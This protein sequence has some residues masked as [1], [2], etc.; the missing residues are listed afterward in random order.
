MYNDELYYTQQNCSSF[1]CVAVYP[2]II[3]G[4]EHKQK[5]PE[6]SFPQQ[7]IGVFFL[8]KRSFFFVVFRYVF[9]ISLTLTYDS[10]RYPGPL[11][12]PCFSLALLLPFTSQTTRLSVTSGKQGV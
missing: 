8:V 9:H 5:A 4:S 11:C 7:K 10:Y 3:A 6:N 1:V 2:G 12:F